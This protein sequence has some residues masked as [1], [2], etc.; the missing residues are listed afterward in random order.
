MLFGDVVTTLNC[1]DIGAGVNIPSIAGT[2]VNAKMHWI[3]IEIDPNRM[4][5]GAEVLLMFAREWKQ[6]SERSLH[7]GYLWGDCVDPLNL[8]G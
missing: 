1:C 5:L 6:L 8:R 7:I 3:G 4:R 2:V